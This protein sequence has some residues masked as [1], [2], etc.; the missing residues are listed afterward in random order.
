MERAKTATPLKTEGRYSPSVLALG[1]KDQNKMLAT[2]VKV[3]RDLAKS[4]DEENLK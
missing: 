2:T 1:T 3:C 4:L